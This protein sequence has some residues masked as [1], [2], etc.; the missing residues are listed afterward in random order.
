MQKNTFGKKGELTAVNYLKDNN[1]QILE[2][3]YKNKIG[4][5]D[6]IAKDKNY[7]VFIEVKTRTSG[8]FGDPLEAINQKKQLKIR[9][10]ATIY[11]IKN[12][13]MNSPCRFD[14]ISILGNENPEIRHVKD[15]F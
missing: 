4:E 14:A 2:V 12:K 9:Q 15:A 7:I 6:I 10:V 13:L 11:L 5:I 3:N 8:M 1:Y